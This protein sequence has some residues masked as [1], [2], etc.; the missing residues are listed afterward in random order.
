[1][2]RRSIHDPHTAA[3]VPGRS[4]PRRMGH[5]R[6]CRVCRAPLARQY[7]PVH[8]RQRARPVVQARHD[9]ELAARLARAAARGGAVMTRAA[10]APAADSF[11]PWRWPLDLD[12]Y[13]RAPALTPIECAALARR[14][15]VPLRLGR[16]T[17]LFH[18]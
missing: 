3:P 14:A 9:Y 4:G 13:D 16:W 10:I 8:P 15:R 18:P 1:V 12:T 7:P 5:S 11:T 17:P 6:D 2:W